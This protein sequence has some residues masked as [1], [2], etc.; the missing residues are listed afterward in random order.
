M[1][2]DPGPLPRPLGVEIRVEEVLLE[3][4]EEPGEA[5][6]HPLAVPPDALQRGAGGCSQRV[7]GPDLG[8]SSAIVLG[9]DSWLSMASDRCW[10]KIRRSASG[11]GIRVLMKIEYR[12]VDLHVLWT[13]MIDR[14]VHQ[15]IL[16]QT[17]MD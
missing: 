7:L 3:M 10:Q 17:F 16:F 13:P 8:T 11:G 5:M 12:T 14:P 2:A 9:K 6:G 4:G 1:V 15:A